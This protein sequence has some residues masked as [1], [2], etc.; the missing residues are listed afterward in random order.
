MNNRF[1]LPM[2]SG[3][4]LGGIKVGVG[5]IREK[6]GTLHVAGVKEAIESVKNGKKLIAEALAEKG[7]VIEN[8]AS[9]EE[10]ANAIKRMSSGGG[11]EYITSSIRL[12]SNLTKDCNI[13][14]QL[15]FAT[16]C[17]HEQY[18]IDA[19]MDAT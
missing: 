4:T 5:F 10:I 18:I 11:S 14:S 1:L 2:A 8:D 3:R 15:N 19:G 12:T 17:I 7:I 13:S 6:D 16:S 9:F